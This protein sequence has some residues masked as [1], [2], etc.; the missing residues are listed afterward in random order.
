MAS[1]TYLFEIQQLET[2]LNNLKIEETKVIDDPNYLAL[3][4]LNGELE[5]RLKKAKLQKERI[6]SEI[7]KFD[8]D[9]NDCEAHLKQEEDRLYSGKISNPRELDQ[10]Q[11]KLSEYQ[12]SKQKIE[13]QIL[14]LMEQDEKIIKLI[15]QHNKKMSSCQQEL[16]QRQ[17][18]TKLKLAELKFE[19]TELEEKISELTPEVPLEWLERY[20]KIAASHKGIGLA[21][22][23]GTACGACHVSLS[24]SLL[25]KLKRGDDQ[26]CYCENCGRIIC[27]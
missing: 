20:R 26:L 17:K 16:D 19:Q 8:L 1:I 4:Q 15:Q 18:M 12:H 13:A 21:K 27:Y 24:D 9:L 10:I 22:L 5:V 6:S 23:K 7:K 14:A 2:R 11:L 3:E 25:Q